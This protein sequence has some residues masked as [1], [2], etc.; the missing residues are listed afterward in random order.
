MEVTGNI[1]VHYLSEQERQ[2]LTEEYTS[3]RTN[4]SLWQFYELKGQSFQ[5]WWK[6]TKNEVGQP[7]YS[8]DTLRRK[9]KV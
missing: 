7:Q 6:F 8:R 1:Y 2:F 5:I 4:Q 9:K 3:F